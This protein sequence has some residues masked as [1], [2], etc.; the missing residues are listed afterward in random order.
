MTDLTN[1]IMQITTQRPTVAE[2]VAPL[3]RSTFVPPPVIGDR[4][5][6]WII[7]SKDP[8]EYEDNFGVLIDDLPV[9]FEV[10]VDGETS[11][12][13]FPKTNMHGRTAYR[14]HKLLETK[15]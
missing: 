10:Q 13:L 5:N 7:E 11:P 14:I 4:V 2:I 9:W 15:K 3:R 12:T 1:H 6:V 8:D